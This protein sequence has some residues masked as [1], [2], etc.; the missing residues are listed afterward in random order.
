ML[1]RYID[2][3]EYIGDIVPPAIQLSPRL[4][5]EVS[6][7]LRKLSQ[8]EKL[9]K[10]LQ[11]EA[12]QLYEIRSAL[13]KSIEIFSELGEYCSA[14][15]KI[16]CDPLFEASIC[17]IQI[18]QMLG[19]EL[20]L[21]SQES[22]SVRHLKLKQKD[23]VPEQRNEDSNLDD[24]DAILLR[25]KRQKVQNTSLYRDCRYIRPTSNICERLFSKSKLMLGLQ[26]Y[27]ILPINL[28]MQL[29]LHIN[30]VL[31]DIDSLSEEK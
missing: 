13:D 8:I 15:S 22:Y 11:S 21:S 1:Q 19:T 2:L 17:K 10:F 18:N 23:S 16:V 30:R 6:V 26:R 7:L 24:M 9:T 27:R 4:N 25:I 20:S 31:W 12:R 14:N 5:A 3:L 29:F 28:E